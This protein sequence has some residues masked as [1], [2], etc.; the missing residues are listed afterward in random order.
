MKCLQKKELSLQLKKSFQI[1]TKKFKIK[2]QCDAKI[3]KELND[4]RA[5][6]DKSEQALNKV[7]SELKK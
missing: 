7:K 6:L 3:A 4:A 5:E 1:D 2:Q